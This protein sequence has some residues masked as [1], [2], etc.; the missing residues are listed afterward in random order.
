MC[1]NSIERAGWKKCMEFKQE[2]LNRTFFFNSVGNV[3]NTLMTAWCVG[4]RKTHKYLALRRKWSCQVWSIFLMDSKNVLENCSIRAFWYFQQKTYIVRNRV[5]ERQSKFAFG[6]R[7]Q[8]N[9]MQIW[10][11]WKFTICNSLNFSTSI[12]F[13]ETSESDFDMLRRKRW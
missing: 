8:K 10:M 5:S 9:E 13:L 6:E 4:M 12:N 1:R 3:K 11:T 7:V 2:S